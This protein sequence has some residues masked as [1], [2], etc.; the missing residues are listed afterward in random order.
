MFGNVCAYN[1]LI[2][3]DLSPPFSLAEVGLLGCRFLPGSLP[4][5]P[6]PPHPPHTVEL[7]IYDRLRGREGQRKEGV[8]LERDGGKIGRPKQVW[9]GLHQSKDPEFIG[10]SACTWP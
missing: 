3:R 9:L 4:L 10:L 8:G 2:D 5:S 1:N 7:Q 6:S